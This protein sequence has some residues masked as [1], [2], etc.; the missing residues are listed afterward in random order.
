M[1]SLL[2]LHA[3]NFS[4]CVLAQRQVMHQHWLK[5]RREALTSPSARRGNRE[6]LGKEQLSN[7]K[8]VEEA[9]DRRGTITKRHI[10]HTF[11]VGGENC[12]QS[13]QTGNY[14]SSYMKNGD[15]DRRDLRPC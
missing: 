1:A 7:D 14:S 10:I 11:Y 13:D 9:E 15:E 8:D 5:L 2:A 3:D 6:R 4:C 12:S